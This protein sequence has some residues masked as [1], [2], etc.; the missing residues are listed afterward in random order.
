[1]APRKPASGGVVLGVV[2]VL[3]VLGIIGSATNR[4]QVNGR[5]PTGVVTSDSASPVTQSA[6]PATAFGEGTYVVGTDIVA[7]TY[8]TSGLAPGGIGCSWERLKDTSGESTAMIAF[9][10]THGPATVTISRSDGAFETSGC[11]TWHKMG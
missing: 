11:D 3:I 10:Y 7:G 9:N 1:M 5:Q 2:G 4:S 6:G 8:H